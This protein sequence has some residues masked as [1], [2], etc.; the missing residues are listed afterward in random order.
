LVSTAN[1]GLALV[2]KRFRGYIHKPQEI[3]SLM[4]TQGLAR[5]FHGY[6]GTFSVWE[7]AVYRRQAAHSAAD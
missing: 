7:V 3:A 1:V 2:K 6:S 4:A 5:V